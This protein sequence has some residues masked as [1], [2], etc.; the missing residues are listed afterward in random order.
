VS[1]AAGELLPQ[2]SSEGQLIANGTE[3]RLDPKLTQIHAKRI[4]LARARRPTL[5][6]VWRGTG[7]EGG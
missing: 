7:N 2:R 4:L 6:N 3:F 1:D 5:P